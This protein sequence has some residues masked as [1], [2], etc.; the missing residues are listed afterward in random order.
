MNL[1]MNIATG[2]LMT[3]F[4]TIFVHFQKIAW[5]NYARADVRLEAESSRNTSK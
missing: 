5:A 1:K 4:R 3:E 2:L